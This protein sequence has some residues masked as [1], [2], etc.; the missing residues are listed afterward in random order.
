MD[1]DLAHEVQTTW[2]EFMTSSGT[3]EAAG[4]AIYAAL[5]ESA[6]SLQTLFKSPRAVMA[7]RFMAGLNQIVSTIDDPP[8]LK[9]CVET[10]GFQHLQLEVTVPRVVIFRDA[11]CDLLAMEVGDNFSTA[12]REAWCVVLNYVGGAFIYVRTRY[13]ERLS[14][15]ATSWATAN[16]KDVHVD[17]SPHSTTS[18][19][20]DTGDPP[21]KQETPKQADGRRK[22]KEASSK[23]GL[24][25]RGKGRSSEGAEGTDSEDVILGRNAS[26]P[27]T[28]NEMFLFN[29]IVM[30][31]G[32]NLWMG[33]VLASF[34]TIVTN[35]SNS[36]RLQEE[37]DILSLHLSKHRGPIVLSE[38][39]AVMLASL[40]SLVPQ[41]WNS[42]H[43]VA[44]SWL[45]ENVERMLKAMMGK[46]ATMEKHLAQLFDNMTTEQ[47]QTVR[48]SVYSTFFSRHPAGQDVFKQSTTR[49]HFI[50][51]RVLAMTLEIYRNPK[52]MAEDISA[53]GLRHVG[54]GISTD[55]FSPFVTTCVDVVRGVTDDDGAEEGF[56]W[57]LSLI[58]RILVRVINEGDTIVMRAI[59][60]NCG[61]Q[62]TKAVGCAPRGQRA[63]WMLNVQVG[64]QSISPLIWA[65]ET[66]SLDAAKAI[67][68]DLLTIRADRDRYY[69]GVDTM[70]ERHP[71]IIER[72]CM[73]APTLLPTLLDGLI[74]RSRVAEK[75]Q[76]RVNYY[77]K[78]LLVDADG[79][80]APAIQWIM[81]HG[82][83]KLTCHPAITLVLDLVWSRVAFHRF[84]FNKS[85]F[86]FTLL[87]FITSQAVL[88]E[89]TQSHGV[90]ER[91]AVFV[92][93][94]F[95][96]L[97][98]MCHRLFLHAKNTFHDIK[99]NNVVRVCHIPV[100]EY[101][102]NWQELASLLLCL[103]LALMLTT[104]PILHCAGKAS[105]S[106][107]GAGLWTEY[108]PEA[109]NLR[110]AYSL[111]SMFAMLI[112][113]S[114]IIDLSVL[115]TKISA[116][117]LVCGR[118]LSELGL[119]LFGFLF[120][121]LAFSCGVTALRH[122]H[123]DFS[124]IGRSALAM[125][126]LLLGMY[127][128]SRVDELEDD[129]V[130]LL[131][132]FA[133][134]LLTIVFLVNLLVAQL[135]CSYQATYQDMLGFA[136]LN[137][138]KIVVEVMLT[139]PRW[140]WDRVVDSLELDRRVEFGEGDIGLPGGIQVFEPASAHP[141]TVDS[142][143][144]YGGSTSP[145]ERWPQEETKQKDAED[146]LK[147]MEKILEKVMRKL[148][149]RPRGSKSGGDTSGGSSSSWLH[150]NSDSKSTGSSVM[151]GTDD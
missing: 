68:V 125:S 36:Y 99:A 42:A 60:A 151:G 103:V 93:R 133:Y 41:E 58:S 8:E 112:Y 18:G 116:F 118:V 32:G 63:L 27:R 69:Y 74:W 119:F 12:A 50:A 52:K 65:I 4:E 92:C 121:T 83:P 57:S 86:I 29:A 13:A 142:I 48:T 114:L 117:V 127:N 55:L 111:L 104:E 140:R 124:G 87:V 120:V 129:P 79:G 72:L 71:D 51:D 37:C 126:K 3:R 148:A 84:L 49:L 145:A 7:V 76:R 10:L 15:L 106:F 146:R 97:F 138:G 40:R 53:L 46:P 67:I 75:G 19:S 43:E 107:A 21:K 90:A 89:L 149:G 100:V 17:E 147:R 16:N 78:H 105:G 35:V 70:F 22:E 94:A 82:N 131:T 81:D 11:I 130:L 101:L 91:A 14:I 80:F 96:Y 150:S 73:D 77:V 85:W 95:I 113:F 5:F 115:S 128:G 54:Y 44:W 123:E 66:G 28:F 64:T 109:E 23:L 110:F 34:D 134:A 26:V 47:R 45:W 132:I 31:F 139:C 62:L 144:R 137:R 39:K 56:R 38:F 59:N 61:N 122:E 88:P 143:R 141:T 9:V 102:T 108:C 98:C 136:R 6:P 25:K 135:S 20:H 33:E 2:H 1:P 24:P 30:G